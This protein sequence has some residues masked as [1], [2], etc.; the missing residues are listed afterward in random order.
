MESLVENKNLFRIAPPVAEALKSGEPVL[1][2]E[3]SI[4]AQGMPR[5][6]NIDFARQAEALAREN[7]AIPATIA[8]LDGRV[9]IG[10]SIKEL[11]DLSKGKGI[12]K[13][14]LRDIASVINRQASGAT[15]VSATLHLAH[16]AGIQVLATGGI[17]GV[18]R[19]ADQTGDISQDL[20]ALGRIPMLVVSSGAKAILDLPKTLE[21]LETVGVPVVGYQS[22]EF[23]AFYSRN[24][25]LKLEIRA[26]KAETIVRMYE[27]HR[28]LGLTSAI[29]VANPIPARY[30]IASE[31]MESYLETS[32][33]ECR[34]NKIKGKAVTPFLLNRFADL[35]AGKS[36]QAN[37]A[38]ALNN[39]RLGSEIARLI[40]TRPAPPQALPSNH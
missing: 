22:S 40:G 7:G 2:L 39:V 8:I 27:I 6:Q 18:H 23:P 29:L 26:D 13:V 11:E 33:E 15:T 30:E 36:L 38:L 9:H 24:S 14:A 31:K 4:I 35:T 28:S 34:R 37:V 25:G 10:L 19:G 21:A 16:R 1:A 5:P 20:K 12:E 17:G 32:L 3:S